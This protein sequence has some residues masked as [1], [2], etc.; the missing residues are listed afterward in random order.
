MHQHSAFLVLLLVTAI[1]AQVNI[2]VVANTPDTGDTII[3]PPRPVAPLPANN[4]PITSSVGW[5]Y[6]ELRSDA[7]CGIRPDM[8]IPTASGSFPKVPMLFQTTNNLGKCDIQFFFPV[9]GPFPLLSEWIR[10]SYSW[11]KASSSTSGP[12][13]AP[14]F[15]INI[16]DP[17]ELVGSPLLPRF[18]SLVYEPYKQPGFTTI[19][20][21]SWQVT[22]L[23]QNSF[24]WSTKNLQAM[25]AQEPTQAFSDWLDNLCVLTTSPSPCYS[26]LARIVGFNSGAGSGWTGTFTGASDDLS[27]T[28]SGDE[29]TNVQFQVDS[30]LATE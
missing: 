3:A 7:T 21:D 15:R 6:N 24:F 26:P 2:V 19:T 27:W 22:P 25:P 1:T 28:L 12:V 11:F 20:Q 30:T 8:S 18:S 4:V 9:S 16:I 29:T 14:A 23:D 5:S 10:G 17:A 13:T